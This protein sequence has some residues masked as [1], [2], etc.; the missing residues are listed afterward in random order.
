ML[1]ATCQLVVDHSHLVILVRRHLHADSLFRT[2]PNCLVL[3]KVTH[4]SA[5][6]APDTQRRVRAAGTAVQYVVELHH[7]HHQNAQIHDAQVI[8]AAS[9]S[10]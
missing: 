6:A 2:P 8:E 9:T 1:T 5:A 3:R 10:E 7:V 4:T